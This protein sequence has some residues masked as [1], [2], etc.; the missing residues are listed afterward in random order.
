MQVGT[1]H[2]Y[3]HRDVVRVDIHRTAPPK[4]RVQR[5][6]TKFHPQKQRS[7]S[8]ATGDHQEVV[9]RQA[10][11]PGKPWAYDDGAHVNAEECWTCFHY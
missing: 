4:V 3:L 5:Q 2:T 6:D 10:A 7:G 9:W 1:T 11:A 8:N